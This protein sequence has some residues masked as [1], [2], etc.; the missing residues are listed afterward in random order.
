VNKN[1]VGVGVTL[2]FLGSV[3]IRLY[4]PSRRCNSDDPTDPP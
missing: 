2:R 1:N 4:I 3:C